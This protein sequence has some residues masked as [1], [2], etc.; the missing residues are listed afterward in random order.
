MSNSFR[1]ATAQYPIG[2]FADWQAYQRHIEA[3]T[4]AAVE[5]GANFLLWPEYASME[6]A[7]LFARDVQQDLQRQLAALQEVLDAFRALYR[8]LASRHSVTIQ[9]GT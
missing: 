5:N 4:Q 7:S 3:W 8:T 2:Y 6:L 1:V 9:P